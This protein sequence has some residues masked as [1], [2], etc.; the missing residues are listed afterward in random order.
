MDVDWDVDACVLT[1]IKNDIVFHVTAEG[2]T[3][4]NQD[5]PLS[6]QHRDSFKQFGDLKANFC[7]NLFVF[8]NSGIILLTNFIELRSSNVFGSDYNLS[9]KLKFTI[10]NLIAA[11]AVV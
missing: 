10:H 2:I 1:I 5:T 6:V 9:Y 11:F 7:C 4:L 8:F 3:D